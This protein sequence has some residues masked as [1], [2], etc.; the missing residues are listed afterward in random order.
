M[1]NI[2]ATGQA[3]GNSLMFEELPGEL[4][5]NDELLDD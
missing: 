5:P 3:E 4:E 2:Y 1:E